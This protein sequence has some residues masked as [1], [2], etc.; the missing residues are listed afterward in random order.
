LG[1]EALTGRRARRP[2][3]PRVPALSSAAGWQTL[4]LTPSVDCKGAR[5]ER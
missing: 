3:R 2:V 4:T 5:R 1:K